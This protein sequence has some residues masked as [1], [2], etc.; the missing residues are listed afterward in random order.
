MLTFQWYRRACG[1]R[2]SLVAFRAVAHRHV[3]V[4]PA[5]GTEA[6]DARARIHALVA[7][8][9]LGTV[10]VGMDRT[11]GTTALVRVTEVLRQTRADS[12]TVVLPALGVNAT[13]AR[14]AGLL[15]WNRC[16]SCCKAEKRNMHVDVPEQF[17]QYVNK[18]TPIQAEGQEACTQVT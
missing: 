4:H 11:L 6:T 8:T 15:L 1:E 17:W 2:V 10:T 9:G 5:L 16:W 14:V 7:F 13:F 3:V 12:K 18:I